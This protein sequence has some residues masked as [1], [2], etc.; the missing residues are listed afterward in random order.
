MEPP[1]RSPRFSFSN[2]TS[3]RIPSGL[4]RSGALACLRRHFSVASDE[5]RV[6]SWG[7][8][9][10]C[11][12]IEFVFVDD[13]TIRTLN[14]EHRGKDEATD[15]LT[16]EAPDFPGAPLGEIVIA[17]PFAERQ[18]LL[19]KVSLRTELAYLAIHGVLHLCGFDDIE[20]ADRR[21]MMAEMASVGEEIGLEPD[22]EW[23]SIALGEPAWT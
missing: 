17:V 10:R 1:S 7:R 14:R 4:I 20:E 5:L 19:R 22:R 13:E 11:L 18:A 6:T 21:R 12:D 16:F 15:V 9:S 23:T 3:R 8:P 2:Q